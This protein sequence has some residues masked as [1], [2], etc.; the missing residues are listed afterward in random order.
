MKQQ[1]QPAPNALEKALSD[2]IQA[3]RYAI[4]FISLFVVAVLKT[5]TSNLTQV[6]LAFGGQA[7]SESNYKRYSAIFEKQC[8]ESCRNRVDDAGD[9]RINRHSQ[10]H[11]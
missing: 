6:A 4:N 11:R 7:T 2:R 3:I 9:A 1:I 10:T 5:K 8:V